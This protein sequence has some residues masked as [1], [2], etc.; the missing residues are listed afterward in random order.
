MQV[1]MQDR[2]LN[3]HESFAPISVQRSPEPVRSSAQEGSLVHFR[4]RKYQDLVLNAAP[5]R[6]R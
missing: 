1:F 3:P 5:G 6:R 4:R 2:D